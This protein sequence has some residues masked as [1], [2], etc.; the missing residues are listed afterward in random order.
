MSTQLYILWNVKKETEL[1]QHIQKTCNV[2]VLPAKIVGKSGNFLDFEQITFF[3]VREKDAKLFRYKKVQD[4]SG[5]I[6]DVIYP[7][8]RNKDNLP[9][10]EYTREA[11]DDKHIGR[12]Y[13]PTYYN[14]KDNS[15]QVRQIFNEIKKWVV[16]NS[17]TR[18]KIDTIS[19]YSV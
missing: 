9:Y 8:D 12:I 15:P 7:F 3:L 1:F 6:A 5:N 19:I 14:A 11:Y 17:I 16:S 13:V 2:S 4:D 10:I 18:E